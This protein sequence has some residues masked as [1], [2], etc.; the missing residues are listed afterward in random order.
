[1]STET[2]SSAG[3]CPPA[4]LFVKTP[5]GG[6]LVSG[7]TISRDGNGNL[8]TKW[9]TSFPAGTKAIIT[10]GQWKP[11][12]KKDIPHGPLLEQAG[13]HE[14]TICDGSLI[15]QR[16]AFT[17]EGTAY[18]QGQYYLE[19]SV[20]DNSV[21]NQPQ[22]ARNTLSAA[23][24]KNKAVSKATTLSGLEFEVFGRF[25]LP[26]CE[27]LPATAQKPSPTPLSKEWAEATTRR[28]LAKGMENKM[29][30]SGHPVTIT[31][32]GQDNTTITIESP[33][34]TRETVMIQ[35]GNSEYMAPFR[36]MHFKRVVFT[37]GTDEWGFDLK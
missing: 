15:T 35:A 18:N 5:E 36:K 16:A 10:L 34:F 19:L 14:D 17:N 26:G 30:A 1:M 33:A 8:S 24:G 29:A 4:E 6:D 32:S 20:I 25:E 21:W 23:Y 27:A 22:A 11:N 3:K 7:V 9:K 31:V 12:P 13:F 2:S 37:N 28:L